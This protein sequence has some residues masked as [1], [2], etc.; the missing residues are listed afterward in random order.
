M[1]KHLR[2][3]CWIPTAINTHSEYVTIIC[4][5]TATMNARNRLKA[6]LKAH[7][8][9]YQKKAFCYD[10]KKLNG[11]EGPSRIKNCAKTL[12]CRITALTNVHIKIVS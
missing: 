3:A 2:T 11:N 1:H 8:L 6:T 12:E 4:F 9:S 5:S 7:R 10:P